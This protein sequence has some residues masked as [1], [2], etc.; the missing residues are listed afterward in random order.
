MSITHTNG[1]NE[2]VTP[3]INN[4]DTKFHHHFFGK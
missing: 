1:V 4:Y 3:K 2:E